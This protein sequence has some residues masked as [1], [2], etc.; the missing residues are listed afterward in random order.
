MEAIICHPCERVVDTMLRTPVL[1]IEPRA[2]HIL[3]KYPTIELRPSV[4]KGLS[5]K[6]AV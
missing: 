6:F 1:G 3:G 2:L 4:G 5:N